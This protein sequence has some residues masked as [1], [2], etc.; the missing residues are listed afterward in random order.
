MT[1]DDSEE[2]A[3]TDQDSG[4]TDSSAAPQRDP[5]TGKFRSTEER[6]DTETDSDEL[7]DFEELIDETATDESRG[8][9]ETVLSGSDRGS[10]AGTTPPASGAPASGPTD[11]ASS[12]S[13]H[14]ESGAVASANDPQIETTVFRTRPSGYSR[15]ARMY[16]PT[17]PWLWLPQ[18]PPAHETVSHWPD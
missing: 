1:P 9:E 15:P 10:Q 7:P 5:E 4:T 3:D 2:Q 16:L 13:A 6:S 17:H 12:H 14:A 18:Q 11:T 8:T